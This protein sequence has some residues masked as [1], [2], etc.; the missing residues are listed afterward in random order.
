MNAIAKKI[1]AQFLLPFYFLLF[2]S[3]MVCAQTI[4]QKFSFQS[5]IRNPAGQALQNQSVGMRLSILQG[6]ETGSVVYSETH[7]G[8]TNASG[9]VTLQVGGGT[10]VSG[11][12]ATINWAN[13]PFYIKTETDPEGGTNYSIT[14]TSQL[15]SVPYA[16]NAANGVANGTANNQMMYWNGTAWVTLAAP[17]TQGQVL[18]FCNGLLIWTSGG[19][20]P[21]NLPTLT[22]TAASAITTTSASSGGNISSDGGGSI[23]ARGVVWS[24]S[25]NPTI[26]LSTKTSDGTGSGSFSS[27][28][29]GLSP[30]TFYY[31]R[32]YATNSAGTAYGSQ[33]SFTTS[34]SLFTN[35][36]GVIDFDG[37]SYNSIIING[38]EWMKENLKVS[39]YRNGDPI[40]EVSDVEQWAAI[41]NNGTPTGQAAW[42]YYNND[43][44]NNAT[45]G[46]LY[47]WYAV[48]DPRGLCPAGWHV[49]SDAEWYTLENYLDPTVNNPNATGYRG[50]DV[51]G[52]LKAVSSL[53]SSPNT[54][55]TNSSGF[56]AFPGGFRYSEELFYDVGYNGAW[57]S[58]TEPTSSLAWD[59]FLNYGNATSLR[60]DINFKTNGLSVRCLRD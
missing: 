7:L 38:Q 6:S 12:M 60:N 9:L 54:G 57:W 2:N 29:T 48:A 3:G 13:G 56:T 50:T 22:T 20:C 51:G 11:S 30:N 43:A 44:A 53:W 28:L 40:G 35:G 59:R 42:C 46:K 21:A 37:N 52:K 33:V 26:A 24:T 18:T 34:N 23:T 45:Y 17:Q 55:A 8:T 32:A 31:V 14:G 15:L 27:S 16:L 10:V 25:Q 4:L 1:A 36:E 47:N 19:L 58:S 49:P 41:W 5:I 39:K